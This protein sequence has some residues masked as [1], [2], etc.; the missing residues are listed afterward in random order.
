MSTDNN[1]E[2]DLLY[3]PPEKEDDSIRLKGSGHYVDRS[4]FP[5]NVISAIHEVFKEETDPHIILI[6]YT[7]MFCG[8]TVNKLKDIFVLSDA[9]GIRRSSREY[10]R[11]KIVRVFKDIRQK[12]YNM[13]GS[14]MSISVLSNDKNLQVDKQSQLSPSEEE[15]LMNILHSKVNNTTENNK[16]TEYN[17]INDDDEI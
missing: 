1:I 13:Y 16:G 2:D 10:I 12:Y 11:Q 6:A 9:Y 14:Q 15:N 5:D 7:Y 3:N 8:L 4:K 17:L